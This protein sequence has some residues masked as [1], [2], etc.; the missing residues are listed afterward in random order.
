[1]RSVRGVAVWALLVFLGGLAL[2]LSPP[3]IDY[4]FDPSTDWERLANIGQAYG[5]VSMLLSA[6]ALVGVVATTIS[7]NRQARIAL[8]YAQRDQHALLLKMAIDDAV[9]M[10]CWGSLTQDPAPERRRQRAYIN[11]IL[12]F[13][14]TTWQLGGMP[15]SQLRGLLA[16]DIFATE[17]GLRF[18]EQARLTR[19]IV[20]AGAQPAAFDRIVEDEYLRAL[21]KLRS[22]EASGIGS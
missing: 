19:K 3:L 15:E 6:L 22:T 4:A 11:L 9:L 10:E 12:N 7:Q 16:A 1:M 18:W 2:L 13:W 14:A 20:H 5:S 17:I 21:A 8:E